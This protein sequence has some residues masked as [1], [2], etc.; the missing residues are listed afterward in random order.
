M[1][2]FIL[3]GFFILTFISVLLVFMTLYFKQVVIFII[4]IIALPF[5]MIYLW[6]LLVIAAIQDT[7][8]KI[9]RGFKE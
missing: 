7:A 6:F 4:W 3:L 9:N 8:D 5:A 2:E 1:I